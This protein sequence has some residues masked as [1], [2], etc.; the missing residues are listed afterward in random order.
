MNDG[1]Y[2]EMLTKSFMQPFIQTLNPYIHLNKCLKFNC[3]VSYW[4]MFTD[5]L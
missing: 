5:A 2:I 3:N 4:K 1:D